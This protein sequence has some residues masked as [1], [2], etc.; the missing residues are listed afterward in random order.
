MARRTGRGLP[1]SSLS[2]SSSPSPSPSSLPPS[3]S[4]CPDKY[5]GCAS[6]PAHGRASECIWRSEMP[7]SRKPWPIHPSWFAASRPSRWLSS[8]FL[9]YLLH[10]ALRKHPRT[11]TVSRCTTGVFFFFFFFFL[12]CLLQTIFYP[13]YNIS[14]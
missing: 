10:L 14:F 9:L 3:P 4:A 1:S 6:R 8:C 11:E 7:P 5:P 12:D 13:I 2:S